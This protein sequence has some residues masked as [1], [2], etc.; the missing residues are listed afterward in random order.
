[1]ITSWMSTA[2][3]LVGAFAASL[4]E[5]VEALTVVLAVG[6]T[7]GWRSALLGA[8]TAL[9]LLFVLVAIFGPSLARVSLA[10]LQ[11]LVGTLLLLFGLRWL[12]KA[13]LRSGGLLARHDEVATF[14]RETAVLHTIDAPVSTWDRAG[15]ATAFNIVMLEGIEVVFIVIALGTG[16]G[17]LLAA[18]VGAAAALLA[19]IALGVALHRPLGRV[20][21]NALKFGV[22]ALLAAFGTFWASEG[23]RIQWPHDEWSLLGLLGGYL[24]VAQLLV[25]LCRSRSVRQNRIKKTDP[26]KRSG[27]ISRAL[28][29]V[30]GLFVDDGVLAAGIVIW[31]ALM[32]FLVG[33]T[34]LPMIALDALIFVGLCALVTYSVSRAGDKQFQ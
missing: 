3:T 26:A 10:L 23:L 12:R 4:V 15:V 18:V 14:V 13:I 34:P 7:R 6:S 11:L 28:K 31:V 9:M 17:R 1:M 33:A 19:V 20:P 30:V 16:G 25:L 21:E 29:E 22:G 24:V 5:F 2:P 32:G 27:A 8:S